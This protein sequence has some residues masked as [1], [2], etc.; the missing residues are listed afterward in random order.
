MARKTK[1]MAQETRLQII[2]AARIVFHHWGVNRSSLEMVARAAGLTRGAIYWHF[3]GKAELF[4]AVR[5]H[6]LSPIFEDIDSIVSA[7]RDADPL[8]GIEAALI[9]F[10]QVL[11]NCPGVRMVLETIANSCEHVA[12]FADVRLELDRPTTEFLSK[13]EC[14]YHRAAASGTLRLGLD[15]NLIARDTCVFVY[16]LMYRLLAG[17]A[18]GGLHIRNHVGEMITLHMALR[19]SGQIQQ[20]E[21]LKSVGSQTGSSI[22]RP[23]N[24]R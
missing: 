17:D 4:L 2:D 21:I 24:Q 19:R 23:T 6:F 8:D 12:E 20:G 22:S 11:D 10:F 1:E 15:P 13:L 3:R 9:Q 16:G 7:E 18:D 5:E 14:A